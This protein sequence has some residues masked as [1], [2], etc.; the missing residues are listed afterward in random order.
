M[1]GPDLAD[2]FLPT[3]LLSSV[4]FML[5]EL[6][7]GG[8]FIEWRAIKSGIRGMIAKPAHIQVARACSLFLLDVLTVVPDATN[9]NELAQFV[10]FSIGALIVIRK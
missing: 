10:P 1:T 6:Y 9:T 5:L 8:R 7:V 3:A 4:G 2:S